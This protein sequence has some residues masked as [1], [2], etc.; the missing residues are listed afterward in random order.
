MKLGISCA[1][2]EKERRKAETGLHEH[3]N[4]GKRPEVFGMVSAF[5]R[6]N[7]AL[8]QVVGPNYFKRQISSPRQLSRRGT[9]NVF[10][11]TT[12]T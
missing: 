2:R 8:P 11:Q 3:C 6:G 5:L 7:F 4:L 12:S 10:L 1:R 9:S